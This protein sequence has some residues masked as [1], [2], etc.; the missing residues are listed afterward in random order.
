VVV[1]VVRLLSMVVCSYGGYRIAALL[2]EN[3]VLRNPQQALAIIV[4]II[5]G[6]LI[7]YVLGGVLGR[8]SASALGGLDAIV[9]KASGADIFFII[10]GALAGLLVALLPSVAL[11]HFAWPGYVISLILFL[12][13][14]FVGG[15]MAY[16]KRAELAAMFKLGGISGHAAP[17]SS[18]RI[19]DT[20]VII[21]GRIADI[22]KAGFLD[23]TMVVPRFVLEE[24][25]SVAD[26]ADNLKRSRGRRGLDVL[27]SLQRLDN[28]RIE[29][30]D[31][32]F[33][34]VMGV[35]SKLTTLSKVTGMPMV[36]NDFN[37]NRVAELQGVQILNINELAGAL[38]PVVLPGEEMLV[39]IIREGKEPGQG[40]G[41]LDDGTMI[42]VEHGKKAIGSESTV[43]ATSVLQTP[44][45]KMIFTELKE[46]AQ[47]R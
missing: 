34:E 5:L 43:V 15:R 6:L 28:V 42:V 22:A 31:Q 45:G 20:S 14:G 9:F 40:V 41:Y 17:G 11:L 18:A 12:F 29:I 32:D 3:Y 38:R 23:G 30:T 8:H 7:G 19:L 27:N 37:L 33:P 39:K 35:D 4:S 26:S 25:Q 16:I 36:T 21:D 44:A 1:V 10:M 46:D 13:G 2:N 24:L 47:E